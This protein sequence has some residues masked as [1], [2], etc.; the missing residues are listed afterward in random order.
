[1]KGKI[2]ITMTEEHTEEEHEQFKKDY[3]NDI[4][5]KELENALYKII[6]QFHPIKKDQIDIEI[7]AED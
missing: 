6:S 4:K 3:Q 5:V 2:I 7:K 1:M